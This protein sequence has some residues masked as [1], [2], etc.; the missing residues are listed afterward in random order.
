[1]KSY[2]I[3]VS[4][5]TAIKIVSKHN[6]ISIDDARGYTESELIETL[7]QLNLSLKK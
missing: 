6:C 4:K 7:K 5:E 3:K 1:M 2:R